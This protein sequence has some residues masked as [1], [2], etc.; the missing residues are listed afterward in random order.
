MI[1]MSMLTTQI[2]ITNKSVRAANRSPFLK[3][4]YMDTE[5]RLAAYA[6]GIKKLTEKETKRRKRRNQER[7]GGKII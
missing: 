7:K 4:D 3:G 2:R 1:T 5:K 6:A